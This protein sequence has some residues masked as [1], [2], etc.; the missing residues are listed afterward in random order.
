[1][2][3]LSKAQNGLSSARFMLV[4]LPAPGVI[5]MCQV[6]VSSAEALPCLSI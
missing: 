1:M 5:C 4:R 2:K 6:A 3:G